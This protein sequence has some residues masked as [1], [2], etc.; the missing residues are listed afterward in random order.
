[1]KIEHFDNAKKDYVNNLDTI[2]QTVRETNNAAMIV[3]VGLYNPFFTWFS[4]LKELDEIVETWND[5]SELI[6]GTYEHAYF[7][8]IA[9]L[10][11]FYG[12]SLL[13]TD[14]FHPNDKGYELIADRLYETL[15][16]DVISEL[17]K[18]KVVTTQG[19]TNRE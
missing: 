6:V 5:A 14:Y 8:K 7:V 15:D 13:Y 18:Q 10:F 19:E 4:D 12:E 1:L 2:L 9:D 16:S 17:S 3:L 11:Q